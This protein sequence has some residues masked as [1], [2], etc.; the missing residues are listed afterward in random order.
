MREYTTPNGTVVKCA[1]GTLRINGKYAANVLSMQDATDH[2]VPE[3][4]A[5]RANG[6]PVL[7][8]GLCPTLIVC[9][10]NVAEMIR[11]EKAEIA[12]EEA[13]KREEKKR[14]EEAAIAACPAG[15]EAARVTSTDYEGNY[16]IAAVADGAKSVVYGE[17]IQVA[18][19]CYIKPEHFANARARE[20][21]LREE[22]EQ[23]AK[24]KEDAVAEAAR[25]G[26][27]VALRRWVTDR[28]H[29][30]NDH[31]CSFDN[32]TEWVLPDGTTKITYTCCF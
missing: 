28:C 3:S 8:W 27:R 24:A 6:K 31:D 12:A 19:I 22:A 18:G 10:P 32:A 17:P 20:A 16:F 1:N 4:L 21:K 15:L 2:A 23:K 29:N 25:T 7:M 9:D 30:G 26:K 14:A 13:R 5:K 11:A